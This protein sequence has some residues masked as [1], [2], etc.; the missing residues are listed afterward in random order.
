MPNCAGAIS[1]RSDNAQMARSPEHITQ[2]I[3][4]ICEAIGAWL[5]N[6]DGILGI[7][8]NRTATEGLFPRHDVMFMLDQIA[9]T[10]T[11]EA[12]QGWADRAA[13]TTPVPGPASEM[14]NVLCLHAGNLPLVGLQDIVAT[15]L[16]GSV[17]YGK[18]SRKDPWLAD[19]LLRVL[20]KRM[21]GQLGGWA[22][23]L[24]DLDRAGAERVLFAGAETS[25]P[26]VQRRVRE[27]GLAS[28]KALFLPRTA[29]FSMAWLA[30]EDFPADNAQLGKLSRQLAGAMLRYEGRGCRSLALVVARRSLSDF[31]GNLT[32]AAEVFVRKNPPSHFRSPGV[33]YWRSYLNS[34]GKDVYDLGGQI[35]TDDPELIGRDNVI[36]W[37]RGDEDDVRRLV[38]QLG[39]KLQQVYVHSGQDAPASQDTADSLDTAASLD[40]VAS[41]DTVAGSAHEAGMAFHPLAG[42]PGIRLAP[43]S[44]AQSPPIDWQPDGVD[45]LSW[46]WKG[47]SP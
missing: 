22:V 43:L 33:S 36:C 26:E 40:T 2:R 35:I 27:L 10:V 46:L 12:L 28:E 38:R 30:D 6:E 44:E 5:D 13:G 34:T 3:A 39:P 17:Y 18:L 47:Y 21:P 42:V 1:S 31:A 24:E 45:A 37:M 16:S 29:R 41:Q 4:V 9:R 20:R 15:L 7:T 14:P 8:V 32:D 25:V 23:R 19:G 11:L